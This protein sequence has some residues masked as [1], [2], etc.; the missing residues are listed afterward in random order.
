M[1]DDPHA[2]YDC[3]FLWAIQISDEEG[4]RF[5]KLD[6]EGDVADVSDDLAE[7]LPF[8]FTEAELPDDD[9][10]DDDDEDDDALPAGRHP[11]LKP[12][13]P[14]DHDGGSPAG[15]AAGHCRPQSRPSR[16]RNCDRS[17][18]SVLTRAAN[19]LRSVSLSL[20]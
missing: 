8:G 7:L 17:S 5:V 18:A 9:E 12:G 11:A 15:C 3:V 4:A 14:R 10:E 6:Q 2:L 1:E 16:P 19:T 13:R 20:P